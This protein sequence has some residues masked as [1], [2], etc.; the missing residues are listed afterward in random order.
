MN[1]SM[2][3]KLLVMMYTI[4]ARVEL[5]DIKIIEETKI[6]SKEGN[7]VINPDGSLSPSRAD[8]MRKCEYIHNKRLYAYE[9]NT[10]YNL[11]KTYKQGRLFYEYERKPVNDKAYDDIY[12]P[13]KFKAKN[14]YFLRFHTHLINMFPCADG[15][16]S[17]IA[18]RLDAPTSFL[19]KDEV[20]PQSM[21][22]LAALFLLSEQV[23]IP[24]AIEEKKK[25]KKLVLKSVNGE[26]AYIDQSLVLYVNK[27]NSEEKIKTYHTETVKLINFMKH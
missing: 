12:D 7:L 13:Q 26:T 23:D 11:K 6:I 27:K 2:I 3:I 18:G 19:L 22:I 16:L 4:C 17:I 15:A 5:S 9:I 14:D 25:E 24:I 10:M 8:I 20:Q 21:N 1:N